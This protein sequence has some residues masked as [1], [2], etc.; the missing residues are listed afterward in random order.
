MATLVF[1]AKILANH[2]A[3]VLL[4]DRRPS[5]T[6]M[7]RKWFNRYAPPRSLRGRFEGIGYP[8]RGG[9]GETGK[10][11]VHAYVPFVPFRTRSANNS[12]HR[13]PPGTTLQEPRS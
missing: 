6:C 9:A 1:R 11:Q 2:A 8:T 5:L 4:F 13:H 7:L 10:R 12:M 3:L